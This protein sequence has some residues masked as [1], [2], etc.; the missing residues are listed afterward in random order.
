MAPLFHHPSGFQHSRPRAAASGDRG[1]AILPRVLTHSMSNGPTHGTSPLVSVILPVRNRAAWVAHAVTSAL[2]QTYTP[3]EVIAIDDGSTDDTRQ[4]LDRFG[5]RIVVLSQPQAG[6]YAAR[7]RGLQAARGELIAFLDSDDRWFP[8]RLARQ[9][10]LMRRSEVGLVFGD[11][12]HVHLPQTPPAPSSKP[13][14]TC[15]GVTRPAR[16][17][18]AALAGVGQL[19][20]DVDGARAAIVPRRSR[21]VQ[22]GE[23]AVGRLSHVVPHRDAARGGLRRRA[24]GRIRGPRRRHQPRP[25]R[26]L[27]ARIHLFSA[28]AS[29]A[30]DPATRAILRRMLFNL[31][32]HLALAALRGRA[33]EVPDAMRLAWHTSRDAAGSHA[34]AWALAFAAHQAGAR[35]A[36]WF[37][38]TP[39]AMVPMS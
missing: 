17:H 39:G 11:A 26:S 6:A 31:G 36:R 27:Q 29:R 15:F 23:P 32:M 2:E 9:V 13:A 19:H 20:P 24:G 1:S 28:E 37:R 3:I 30:T 18:V 34:P 22:P 12:V 10:P 5:D 8:D 14:R 16:G 7:N 35:T 4:V 38:S 33:R 21:R 25:G